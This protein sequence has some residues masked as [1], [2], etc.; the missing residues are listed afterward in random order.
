MQRPSLFLALAI[1][2]APAWTGS[3]LGHDSTPDTTQ[4][5]LQAQA[6]TEVDNDSMRAV[7]YTEAEDA[8]AAKAADTAN[9]TL[10]EAVRT[11]KA[12]TGVKVRSGSYQT[13]PLYDKQN[14]ISRWR[15]RAEISLE[16]ADFKGMAALLAKLQTTMNLAGVE[17]FASDEA[18]RKIESE[19]T[20]E[21]IEDFRRRAD[22]AAK[23]LGAKSYR[24][25]DL[26]IAADAGGPPMPRPM[27]QARAGAA[28]SEVAPAPIEAGASRMGVQV[29]GTVTLAHKGD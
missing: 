22:V 15:V 17:F 11:A 5:S 13:F 24:I 4:V 3:A 18:R 2:I 29:T 21:A 28:M 14:R 10:G 26:A 27:L 23:A 6:E 8:S 12:Q 7:L 19:L 20:T 9:K 1:L 25:R 16:S